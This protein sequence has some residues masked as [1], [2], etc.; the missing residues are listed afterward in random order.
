MKLTL[1]QAAKECGRAK[2]TLSKAVKSGKLSHEKGDKG[3]YLIDRSELHRVFPP[4]GNEQNKLPVANTENT[5]ENSTLK[6]EVNALRDKLETANTE[7]ERERAQ[8]VEQ[9]EELREQVKEQ[10]SDFRQSLAVLTDQREGQG[11]RRGFFGLFSR[12]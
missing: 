12:A 7:R 8:L 4:T 1:N 3:A 10:R 2:S 11:G 6:V 9:I 5:Q